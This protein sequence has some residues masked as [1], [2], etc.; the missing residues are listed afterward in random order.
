MAINQKSY[1]LEFKQQVVDM[2]NK[3]GKGIT[4]LYNEYGVPKGTISIWVKLLSQV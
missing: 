3:A 1:T 4:E 2:Y